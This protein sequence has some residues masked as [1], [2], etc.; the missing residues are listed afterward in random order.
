MNN[1]TLNDSLWRQENPEKVALWG[2]RNRCTRET[3]K[4]WPLYGGRGIKCLYKTVDEL[5]SDI[6]YKPEYR[7][8]DYSLDR[9][10]NDGNYEKGNCRW[11]TASQQQRNK[12]PF[13]RGIKNE[14]SD[15]V[16]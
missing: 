1:K 2:A 14:A 11:A 6:G 16:S 4:S 9:I 8:I 5:I 15:K 13:K 7:N 10:D 12:R 3:D